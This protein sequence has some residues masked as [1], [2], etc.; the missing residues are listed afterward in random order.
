MLY[1]PTYKPYWGY[2]EPSEIIRKV[3][4][5][6]NS[7]GIKKE[8]ADFSHAQEKDSLVMHY[9]FPW[10]HYFSF[11]LSGVSPKFRL[12]GFF[13]LLWMGF[14]PV[15]KSTILYFFAVSLKVQ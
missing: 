5:C 14:R 10:H 12:R 13:V 7:A 2:E 11:T 6:F 9:A 15:P 3:E 1:I 4:D 8:K